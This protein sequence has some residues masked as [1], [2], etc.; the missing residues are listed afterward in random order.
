MGQDGLKKIESSTPLDP[1]YFNT[2]V[3]G[4]RRAAAVLHPDKTRNLL[5]RER[6]LAEEL[7]KLLT[8]AYQRE[9]DLNMDLNA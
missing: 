2:K 1:P 4:F 9:M 5:E 7:F 6:K 3:L 8:Q